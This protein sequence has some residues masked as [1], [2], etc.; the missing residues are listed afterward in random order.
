[1]IVEMIPFA[2]AAIIVVAMLLEIKTGRIPNWLTFLPFV[3]FAVLLAVVED[4]TP[5]Y[6]QVALSAGVF[7]F[8]IVMFAIGGSGAGAVKLMTGVALFVPVSKA[9]YTAIIFFLV[10]FF[11]SFIFVQ[12]RKAFGSENSSW[13]LMAKQVLPL[14][15]SIGMAGLAGMFLI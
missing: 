5:L 4:R 12:L 7:L 10:F 14:S 15:F 2:V 6:W 9:G 13:H 1:M 3:L 11:S 8:G